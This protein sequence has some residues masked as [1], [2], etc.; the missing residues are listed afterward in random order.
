[1]RPCTFEDSRNCY[2]DAD[3]MGNGIGQDSITFTIDSEQR[4]VLFS[5]VALKVYAQTDQNPDRLREAIDKLTVISTEGAS[6]LTKNVSTNVTQ[7]MQLVE[8]KSHS[9]NRG[10]FDVLQ[11][12]VADGGCGASSL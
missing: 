1:M 4:Q 12:I 10:M 11:A 2:W 9:V 8:K 7:G 6:D 5:E 3:T